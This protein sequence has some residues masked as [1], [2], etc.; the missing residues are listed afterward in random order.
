MA[1]EGRIDLLRS[2]AKEIIDTLTHADTV[3]II[4]FSGDA[5]AANNFLAPAEPEFRNNK[6]KP[7]IETMIAEGTTNFHKGLGGF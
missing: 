4:G 5:S 6:Y 2:A 1:N 3:N 7:Y